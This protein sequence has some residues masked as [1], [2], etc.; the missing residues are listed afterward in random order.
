MATA[1]YSNQ[2][3]LFWCKIIELVVSMSCSAVSPI[4]NSCFTE[5]ALS[6]HTSMPSH[7]T[8]IRRVPFLRGHLI[9]RLLVVSGAPYAYVENKG[10]Y[11]RN[12][13]KADLHMPFGQALMATCRVEQILKCLSHM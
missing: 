10:T 7:V 6:T 8:S 4:F 3:K 5:K 13:A 2:S 11:I 9:W 12:R 1:S